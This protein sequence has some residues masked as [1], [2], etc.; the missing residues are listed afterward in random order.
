MQSFTPHDWTKIAGAALT[1]AVSSDEAYVC[2]GSAANGDILQIRFS[3][4]AGT[5][6]LVQNTLGWTSAGIQETYIDGVLVDTTDLY[7]AGGILKETITVAGLVLTAGPHILETRIN[8]KNA[9][10]GGY[11]AYHGACSLTEV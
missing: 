8:G 4:L 2:N 3:C 1:E 10:S 11:L 6:T 5:Y 7:N 9:S